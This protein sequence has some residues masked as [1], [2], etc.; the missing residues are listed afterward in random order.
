GRDLIRVNAISS[1]PV[2]TLA[3]SKIPDFEHIGKLWTQC[4]PIP[5]DPVRDRQSVANAAAFLLS[6]LATKITGQILAV[7]GGASIM[8]G[9]LMDYE[10]RPS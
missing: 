3:A 7:D 6:P 9:P 10:K 4:A 8:G 5:W 1:G 2:T